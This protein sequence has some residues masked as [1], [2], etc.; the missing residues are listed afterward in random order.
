MKTLLILR[1]AKSSWSEPGLSDHDRPLNQRGLRDAPRMGQFV[2]QARLI[3]DWI[4][5]SSA[6]RARATAERVIAEMDFAGQIHFSTDLYLA[7]PEVWVESLQ[8][9][10][11]QA[12]RVM[13]VGHNPGLESLVFRLTGHDE[14]FPT[15]ALAHVELPV[16]EW[17]E[18]SLTTRGELTALWRPKSL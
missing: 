14:S 18:L 13:I 12:N 16:N 10:D 11:N 7:E 6:N 2:Q 8:L 9:L 5:C 3:P 4:L 17:A 1:H 15:A